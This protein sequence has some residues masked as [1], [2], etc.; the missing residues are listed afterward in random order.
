MANFQRAKTA[1]DAAAKGSRSA[2]SAIEAGRKA[3]QAGKA[4]Q[5]ATGLDAAAAEA[6]AAV[7]ALEAGAAATTAAPAVTT[8]IWSQP[9]GAALR[10][11][12]QAALQGIKNIPGK[13]NPLNW[14]TTAGR[15][16]LSGKGKALV[17]LGA[18]AG[19]EMYPALEY[20]TEFGEETWNPVALRDDPG[21]A[22]ALQPRQDSYTDPT[23]GEQRLHTGGPLTRDMWGGALN[24]SGEWIHSEHTD[25]SYLSRAMAQGD[26][27]PDVMKRV[28]AML[29]P[30]EK[31][32]VSEM[33]DWAKTLGDDPENQEFAKGCAEKWRQARNSGIDASEVGAY[34]GQDCEDMIDDFTE[35]Q[36]LGQR[37][38]G[39]GKR[40]L[41]ILRPGGEADEDFQRRVET[42]PA[43][44]AEEGEA[45]DE[46]DDENVFMFEDSGYGHVDE[47]LFYENSPAAWLQEGKKKTTNKE[48]YSTSLYENLKNKW[49]KK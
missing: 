8:S 36:K 22:S 11:G 19:H 37:A 42:T 32:G 10:Q 21:A 4:A 29:T 12:G 44:G 30:N 13:I 1:A 2:R 34:V 38:A 6:V 31:T 41:E 16:A 7:E 23:T 15:T 3:Q 26:I 24:P 33:E 18:V 9:V 17:G 45:Y 28:D 25:P 5:G 47:D 46:Y 43:E 27:S 39:S 35:D 48:W 14:G 40:P 49:T 20:D